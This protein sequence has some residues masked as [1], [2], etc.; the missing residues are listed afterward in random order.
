M[1]PAQGHT[2]GKRG[3]RCDGSSCPR[4]QPPA[5]TALCPQSHREPRKTQGAP[6]GTRGAPPKGPCQTS[7]DAGSQLRMILLLATGGRLAGSGNIFG[8]TARGEGKL[9]GRFSTSHHTQGG[10]MAETNLSS[11]GSSAE[12]EKP[13]GPRLSGGNCGFNYINSPRSLGPTRLSTGAEM[14]RQDSARDRV[15]R[16]QPSPK[17]TR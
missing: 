16:K 4:A 15:W 5:S 11:S 8:V 10:P 12:A 2:A 7:Y 6:V 3:P 13:A 17:T 1:L 9:G 14:R